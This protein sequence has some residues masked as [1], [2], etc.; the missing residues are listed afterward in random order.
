MKSSELA[1]LEVAIVGGGYGGAVAAVAL[2]RLGANVHVY[3]QASAILQVGAGIGL[4]PPTVELFRRW[5]IFD[6]IA[7]VSTPSDYFEILTATGEVIQRE[8]WPKIHDYAQ[9]NKTRFIHRGDFIDTLLKLLP[10]DMV[11]IGH[12]MTAIEDR[13]EAA[14]LTF[15]DGKKVTADLVIGADGIRSVVRNQLFSDN[16]PVF[17]G[18]HAHRAVVSSG[19]TYGLDVDDNLRL[20][21]DDRGTMI[22]FLPLRHRNQV[23]FDITA[24]SD[25]DSWAP[26]VTRDDL[27]ALVDGFDERLVNIT[28]NLDMDTVTSRA[29]FDIDPVDTWHSD[30]VALLGDAAHAMLHHQGQG[31]NQAIQDAGGLAD[32]LLEAGS[33]REALALY[34]AT[35]KP[36]T[37]A[38][39][40]ISRE[41]WDA[42]SVRTAFPEKS[43][44]K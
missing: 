33:L 22:Y 6:A 13:G 12:K 2:S 7:A 3:E 18:A 9:V 14:T 42:Q 39:Q 21:M 28:R 38:L 44:I 1:N 23:S 32:A 31:A 20:Y 43:S 41:S 24:L 16:Q 17:A 40:R 27:V 26:E 29:V 10:G 4:R 5:E 8:E 30:C 25:D 37:D 34:Q 19:D 15:A 11:H 35:R 36:D